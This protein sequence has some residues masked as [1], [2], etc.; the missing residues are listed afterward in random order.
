MRTHAGGPSLASCHRIRTDVTR[1][2]SAPRPGRQQRAM[3]HRHPLRPSDT[4]APD[5][6]TAARVHYTGGL[7]PPALR[8]RPGRDVI[9]VNLASGGT[10]VE[11]RW[12][13]RPGS[14]VD[15]LLHQDGTAR[16]LRARIERCTVATLADPAGVRYRTALRFE[17]AITVDAPRALIDG[18][19]LPETASP[20]AA[21]GVATSRAPA[22]RQPSSQQCAE[23]GRAGRATDWHP[24]WF[25][26]S[27]NASSED[28]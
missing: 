24:N 25:E 13:F 22:P 8:I 19:V 12:R 7:L 15:V 18:Y 6:R 3:I 1:T 27:H 17:T 21:I 28:A 11:S 9:V 4:P 14:M 2:P 10:L 5:R 26:Y 20:P 16:P 23:T